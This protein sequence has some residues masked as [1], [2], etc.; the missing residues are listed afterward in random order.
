MNFSHLS[1]TQFVLYAND[2]YHS[3]VARL[4]LEEKNLAYQLHWVTDEQQE[5]LA[6]LNPYGGIPPILVNR[7]VILYE[8]NVIFEYLEERYAI[9]K[10]LPDTPAQRAT[11]RLLAWRLQK[12][13]LSLGQILLTHPDS[14]DDT[15][16][17]QAKKTLT[18]SLITL[19]PLFARHEYFMSQTFG[20][21]DVLLL[22][23]LYRLPIMGITLPEQLC[24]PLIRYQT[25]LFCRPSFQKTL[26]TEVYYD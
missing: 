7:D 11:M 9:N 1:S 19:S 3:H 12:D 16:A 6:E 17:N 26:N 25:R 20:W 5:E 8:I 13:W 18:D 15:S 21:C 23:L 14:F 10:L 2:G 22:P 4:L 24:Q